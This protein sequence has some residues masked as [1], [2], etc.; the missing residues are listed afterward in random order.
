M[1][2]NY[3]IQNFIHKIN[4]RP[5]Q[6]NLKYFD[7][8][9]HFQVSSILKISDEVHHEAPIKPRNLVNLRSSQLKLQVDSV[10]SIAI[11][12]L[13]SKTNVTVAVQNSVV[14]LEKHEFYY[15]HI[16]I[17]LRLFVIIILIQIQVSKVN[18]FNSLLFSLFIILGQPNII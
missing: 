18:F 17:S 16:S 10:S 3:S 11:S 13:S 1:N 2:Y 4:I 15:F 12:V 14:S 8:N 5:T 9:F 6:I 7:K